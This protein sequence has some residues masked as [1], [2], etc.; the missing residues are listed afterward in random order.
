MSGSDPPPVRMDLLAEEARANANQAYARLLRSGTAITTG[1]YVAALVPRGVSAEAARARIK[2][3]RL[4]GRLVTVTHERET[5][6]PT[7]QLRRDLEHDVLAGDV[8]AALVK[9]GWSPWGIWDWAETPNPW[10]A[11]HR[12]AEAIRASDLDADRKSVV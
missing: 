7:F 4:R 6:I 9:A 11:R 1:E 2:R 12:P 3:E 10:M 8:V 5:L